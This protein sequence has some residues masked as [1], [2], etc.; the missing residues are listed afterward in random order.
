[1]LS[2]M[3]ILRAFGAIMYIAS[4]SDDDGNRLMRMNHWIPG[5]LL[6][7]FHNHGSHPLYL[8]SLLVRQ[9]PAISQSNS[10][11]S[12][13]D[14]AWF[15]DSLIILNDS[16]YL[17]FSSLIERVSLF[18]WTG[19]LSIL[20]MWRWALWTILL[21]LINYTPIQYKERMF[22]FDSIILL[23]QVLLAAIWWKEPICWA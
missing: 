9:L 8:H 21:T 22:S 13:H 17:I 16:P 2:M 20:I 6:R 19:M 11:Y 4:C 3:W 10:P 14:A 12:F 23:V 7:S 15:H 18:I 1:M 5:N